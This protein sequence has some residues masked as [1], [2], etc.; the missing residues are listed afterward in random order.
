M[1]KTYLA[2]QSIEMVRQM[3]KYHEKKKVEERIGK[4]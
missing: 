1:K 2:N 4:V 3:K